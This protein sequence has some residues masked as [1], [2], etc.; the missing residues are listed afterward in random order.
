MSAYLELARPVNA[1]MAGFSALLGMLVVL[2]PDVWDVDL[3]APVVLGMLV[4]FLV[5]SGGNAL[6]DY[7]DNT[8]DRLAHPERPLPSGRLAPERALGFSMACFVLGLVLAAATVTLGDVELLPLLI[9]VLAVTGLLAYELSYKYRGIAGNVTVAWLSAL[10]FVF[11][12]SCVAGPYEEGMATVLVLFL[13]AFLASA[14]R[15]VTKDIQDAE[16]DRGQRT[17]LPM[18]AGPRTAAATALGFIVLAVAL[19]PLPF[20]PLGTMGWAYLGVVL[21]ADVAFLY[22]L[23][24]VG[25][26][27][28]RAQSIH[29]GGM[30]MALMAFLAGSFAGGSM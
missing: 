5:T 9:A 15:E 1:A 2:G 27:P 22:S 10:T 24:F 13:L 14:G 17:T 7:M 19:S 8:V 20:W 4:P 28:E 26:D 25:R 30:L 3:L 29:K 18:T 6:N 11:G 23:A 21:V 12:A 16:S